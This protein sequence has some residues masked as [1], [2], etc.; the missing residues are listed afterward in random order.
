[1]HSRLILKAQSKNNVKKNDNDD[2]NLSSDDEEEISKIYIGKLLNNRYTIIKY[3]GKGT[4]S[5]LWIIYDIIENS[6]KALKIQNEDDIEEGENEIQILKNKNHPNVINLYDYFIDNENNKLCLVLELLGGDLFT[7]LDEYNTIPFQLLKKIYYQTLNGINFLH[8][9]NIIHT[10][11]KLENILID[12]IHPRN[13][14]LINFIKEK[15]D[16]NF[17][18]LLE[19]NIPE[20]Y[21]EFTP[22][23]RKKTKRKIKLKIIKFLNE[24]IIEL[25]KMYNHIPHEDYNYSIEDLKDIN[26]KIIDL[27]NG[28]FTNDISN[29]EI[30][31]KF[32]RSPENILGFKYNVSTDIWTLGCLFYEMITKKYLIEINQYKNNIDRDSKLLFEMQKYFGRIPTNLCINSEYYE[33]LYDSKGRLLKY[34][35]IEENSKSLFTE[36]SEYYQNDIKYLIELL[37]EM[38][39]YDYKNRISAKKCINHI[40]FSELKN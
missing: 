9:H 33:D 31:Y 6:F 12:K 18:T 25:V 20:N 16:F 15:I 29:E 37:N 27:G 7:L 34:K 24:K 39:N 28:E 23:K 17:D 8:Q 3:L 5:R 22:D 21:N 2:D 14:E 38:F 32:Y 19:N 10:D 11:L 30:S 1:M 26:V 35:N 36:L 4:F 13:M 40:F